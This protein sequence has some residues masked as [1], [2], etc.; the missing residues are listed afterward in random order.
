MR[1]GHHHNN[2]NNNTTTTKTTKTTTT[3]AATATTH[4]FLLQ[5]QDYLLSRLTTDYITS[6]T[7]NSPNLSP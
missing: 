3:T 6:I 5:A 1:S 7:T 4:S 2:N